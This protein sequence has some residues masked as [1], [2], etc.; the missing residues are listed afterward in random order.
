MM[1]EWLNS[2]F[3]GGVSLSRVNPIGIVLMAIA[4]IVNFA[5]KPVSKRCCEEKQQSVYILMK[6]AALLFICIG[7]GAA[8]I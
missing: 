7:A 1:S 3:S 8:M 5:A 2:A 6:V 4:V